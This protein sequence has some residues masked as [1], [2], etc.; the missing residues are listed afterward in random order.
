MARLRVLFAFCEAPDNALDETAG[1]VIQ[2]MT[3][4]TAFPTLRWRTPST[5]PSPARAIIVSNGVQ[6][7]DGPFADSDTESLRQKLNELI[8]ALPR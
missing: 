7:L 3:G 5:P 6:T 8:S 4:N 1:A 2:G